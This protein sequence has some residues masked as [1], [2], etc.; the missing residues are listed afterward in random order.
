MWYT[1]EVTCVVRISIHASNNNGV[2]LF[3]CMMKFFYDV[4]M[5]ACFVCYVS[6]KFAKVKFTRNSGTFALS[7]H[8]KPTRLFRKYVCALIQENATNARHGGMACNY[9]SK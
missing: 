1:Q 7:L 6:T 8:Q 9:N 4:I 2:H 5:C 3:E